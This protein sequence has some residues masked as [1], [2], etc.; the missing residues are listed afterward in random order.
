MK[1][2]FLG[3]GTSCGVPTLG[4]S[5]KVPLALRRFGGDRYNTSA[6]RLWS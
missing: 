4:C 1:I 6:H 3:T 5:C 2:T